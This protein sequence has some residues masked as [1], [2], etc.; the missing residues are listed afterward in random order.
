MRGNFAD[1]EKVQRQVFMLYFFTFGAPN[2]LPFSHRWQFIFQLC[3]IIGFKCYCY[4]LLL[5]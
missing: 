3:N 2:T 1:I 5:V 4:F